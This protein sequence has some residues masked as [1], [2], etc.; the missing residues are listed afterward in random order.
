MSY[1]TDDTID[2]A[3]IIRRTMRPSDGACIVFEGVVRDHHEGKAVES[4]FY[5]A[6]RP[7]AEKEI[8]K[9]IDDVRSQ[10]PDVAI[11]VIHRLGQLGIGDASIATVELVD[12]AVATSGDY[13]RYFD[14][15]GRRYCHLIDARTGWPVSRWQSVS[16]VAPLAI[17]AGSYATIAM[18]LGRDAEAFL[19]PYDVRYLLV[20]ADGAL[21]SGGAESSKLS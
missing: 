6:Y 7:M 2:S 9:I 17:L 11:G 14:A 4:I 16:V 20:D 21:V 1:L 12:G 15:D 8:S 10:L 5:D 13:Q 18:L 3:D 19:D